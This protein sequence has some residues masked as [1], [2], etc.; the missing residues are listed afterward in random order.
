[1][2]R[3]PVIRDCRTTGV[4]PKLCCSFAKFDL[5]PCHALAASATTFRR[6]DAGLMLL[7]ELFVLFSLVYRYRTQ[8]LERQYV[9]DGGG[10]LRRALGRKSKLNG[11]S[12]LP[13]FQ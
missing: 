4:H 12:S 11:Y 10:M 7:F 1:M 2:A 8:R 13:F 3:Y 5:Q 9:R 6:T